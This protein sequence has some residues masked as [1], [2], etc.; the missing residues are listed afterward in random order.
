MPKIPVDSIVPNP[1]QPRTYFDEAE[2]QTL[3]QSIQENGLIV[4]ISVERAGEGY[5]LIDG[6]R[7]WR[8]HKLLG[9]RT[10]D[11]SIRR[12]TNHHGQ[13]RLLQAL[14]ANVQRTG[15]TP[16]EEARAYKKL[17]NMY[18]SQEMVAQKV[19]VS[20]AT[21]SMRLAL[22]EFEPEVQRLYELKRLPLDVKVIAALK[23]LADGQRKQV[24]LLAAT[25]GLSARSILSVCT[26]IMVKGRPAYAPIGRS[27]HEGS[28]ESGHFDALC[29]AHT[30]FSGNIVQATR[31]TCTACPL[32]EDAS[33][34][35]CRQC[36]LV[37]FLRR[38]S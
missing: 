38:L 16:I 20:N 6:E 30:T 17:I 9:M 14:V 12:S 3:A 24:A 25:R 2:L 37:E 7:R 19:G 11:A 15:N 22:L 1:E 10:I 34:S 5:V 31:E 21:I 8:A 35:N 23:G 18:G 32:Y 28:Y 36:P 4:P 33:E 29:L 13:E 27:R 26:R